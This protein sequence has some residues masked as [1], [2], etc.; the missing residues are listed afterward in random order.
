M[1]VVDADKH[2]DILLDIQYRIYL[3]NIARNQSNRT[4]TLKQNAR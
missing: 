3:S 2:N 1:N 4:E